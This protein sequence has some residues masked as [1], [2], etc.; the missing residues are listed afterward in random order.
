M[1]EWQDIKTA[2]KDGTSVML[3]C[4][5]GYICVGEWSENL[6]YDDK[7]GWTDHGVESWTYEQY[8]FID[9]THWQPLPPPPV[10]RARLEEKG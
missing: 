4:S 9:P 5:D 10:I 3:H 2:P 7:S 8:R 1:S 6:N